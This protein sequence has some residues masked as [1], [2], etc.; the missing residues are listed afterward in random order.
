MDIKFVDNTSTFCGTPKCSCQLR[1]DYLGEKI[2]ACCDHTIQDWFCIGDANP[3]E[4]RRINAA[5][6][7]KDF[8][9]WEGSKFAIASTN[10]V[11]VFGPTDS[12][13]AYDAVGVA[14]CNG[15]NRQDK[16]VAHNKRVV[17]LYSDLTP[18]KKI[19]F[20]PNAID[21][22]GRG[23]L[24]ISS[25]CGE[26][27]D[28]GVLITDSQLTPVVVFGNKF[29]TSAKNTTDVSFVQDYGNMVTVL[30]ET[31][32]VLEIWSANGQDL[33]RRFDLNMCLERGEGPPMS[34]ASPSIDKIFVSTKNMVTCLDARGGGNAFY[35][36]RRT[37]FFGIK[38][39][40]TSPQGDLAVV[41]DIE[42]AVYSS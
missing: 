26:N 23:S 32:R 34:V 36:L 6:E 13:V 9:P 29:Q 10:K 33:V 3:A 39:I 15:A 28:Q 2:V 30:D 8:S 22:N 1:Y 14:Q 16:Y 17:S 21:N 42:V 24:I 19:E 18:P 4:S 31:R 5:T 12:T 37:P 25:N 7:I 35:P 38:S 41:D 27:A 20:M 40:A 11:L